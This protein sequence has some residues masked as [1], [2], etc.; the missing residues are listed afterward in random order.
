MLEIRPLN[1]ALGAEVSGLD[2][3]QPLD[4][5][6]VAK[7][8]DA[9][10]KHHLLCIRSAPLE[11][12]EFA[13]VAGYFG[14]PQ[15]QLLRKRRHGETP[16]VSILESTY[17]RPEDKPDDMR[18]VRLSGWHTD[19]SYF[20]TPAKA[21]MLQ[22]IRIPDSGGETKFCN[23]RKAYLDL[24]VETRERLDGLR[25]VHGYDTKRAPARAIKLTKEEENETPD[26]DHPLIRTHEDTG[27]KTIYFN[28]NRTDRVIGMARD[29]SDALLDM[30]YTHVT[31]PKY[32]YHH[33]W[34]AGDILL[35]DNRCL[36]HAVN[37]DFP[38]GQTRL[39]QRILLEGTRPA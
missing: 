8:R 2:L 11:P 35:W 26:V 10:L 29:E 7:I 33:K 28:S 19:D 21:T 13:R 34:R 24:P 6:T 27:E 3:T 36:M 32:Q 1:D 14:K 5:A 12:A 16:E 18:L 4:D 25:A 9:F 39:H 37:M 30:I 38:V 17:K 22:S 23:M 20:A 15:L 31:L